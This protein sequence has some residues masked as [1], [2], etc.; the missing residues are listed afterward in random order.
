MSGYYC[1]ENYTYETNV[2]RHVLN[3]TA[4]DIV[5][6][7]LNHFRINFYPDYQYFIQDASN[8]SGAAVMQMWADFKDVWYEQ[9][10]LQAWGLDNNTQANK[11]A[12]VLY[13]DPEGMAATM[14]GAVPLPPGHY[15]DAR[16][17]DTFN[18]AMHETCWWQWTGPGAHPTN[19]Y[20]AKWM[21][22][23]GIH[24]DKNPHEDGYW[25]YNITGIWVND[26][27]ST[28]S[29]IGANSYKTAEEWNT[30]HYY[31]PMD[32]EINPVWHGK[33]VTLVEPPPVPDAD[34]GIVPAKPRFIDTITPV[35]AEKTVKVYAISLPELERITTDDESLRIV[36]AAIDGVSEELIPFDPAFAAVFARTIPGRPMHVMDGE[37]DYYLVPFNI[38]LRERPPIKIMPVEI[39]RVKESDGTK[40]ERVERVDDKVIIKPIPELIKVERTLV[41]VRVDA[42]DGSFKETSWVD[43]PVKY[44]P[45]SKAEAVRLVLG[46]ID[47][48]S[49]SDILELHPRPRPTI[50][51]VQRGSAPYYPDWKITV[52]DHVFYV[53]QDGTVSQ[54]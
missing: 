3:G 14:I 51:L 17:R 44:L 1:P 7:D 10:V 13:V 29:S 8:Y 18:H 52:G 16:V 19:G 15:F 31:A 46:E 12:G 54:E 50:E 24:T 42:E 26:P 53:N 36:Q 39:E 23:R 34:V 2:T 49:A 43:T 40:L 4:G 25:G 28:A 20:Y 48:R 9:N 30:T 38:P 41:V 22:V 21:S 33:Y 11:D 32:D 6:L 27:D 5:D 35:M 47:V 45:I 37:S